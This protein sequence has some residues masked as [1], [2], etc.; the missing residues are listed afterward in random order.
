MDVV[1]ENWEPH[2]NKTYRRYAQVKRRGLT[3]RG[4]LG[5]LTALTSLRSLAVDPSL[6]IGHEMRRRHRLRLRDMLPQGLQEL[7]LYMDDAALG[8]FDTLRDPTTFG[9]VFGLDMHGF[10]DALPLLTG[11]RSVL[12]M[13]YIRWKEGKSLGSDAWQR[14]CRRAAIAEEVLDLMKSPSFDIKSILIDDGHPFLACHRLPEDWS[15]ELVLQG[16]RVD[17]RGPNLAALNCEHVEEVPEAHVAHE[18]AS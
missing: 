1:L 6:L 12:E 10:Q 14:I 8:K 5:S 16:D 17:R 3:S 11:N 2:M 9:E 13:S 7:T 18:L 4:L 15:H